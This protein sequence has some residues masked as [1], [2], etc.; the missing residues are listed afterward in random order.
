[1]QIRRLLVLKSQFT[2]LNIFQKSTNQNE[3]YLLS[4]PRHWNAKCFSVQFALLT[5]I[6][7]LRF[8]LLSFNSFTRNI[9]EEWALLIITGLRIFL[10]CIVST[11]LISRIIFFVNFTVYLNNL[12]IL[13][14]KNIKIGWI[15]LALISFIYLRRN[16]INY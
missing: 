8:A 6:S 9:V 13:I 7:S 11:G 4:S 14:F 15:F 10:F 12:R 3:I 2:I 1:M 5:P 16:L